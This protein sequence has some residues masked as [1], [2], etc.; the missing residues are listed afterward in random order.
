[1]KDG[2]AWYAVVHGDAKSQTQSLATEQ[3]QKAHPS[4][5]PILCCM[6]LDEIQLIRTHFPHT[7]GIEFIIP[8]AD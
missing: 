5:T 4:D 7:F 3:Q 2:E 1:M 8:E 6:P